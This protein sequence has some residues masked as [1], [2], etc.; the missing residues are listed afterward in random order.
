[1]TDSLAAA[2]A[3][4]GVSTADLREWVSLPGAIDVGEASSPER[5][6]FRVANVPLARP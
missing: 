4:A 2:A 6:S 1:M 5:R 3:Q